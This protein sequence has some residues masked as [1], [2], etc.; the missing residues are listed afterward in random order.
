MHVCARVLQSCLIPSESGHWFLL[1]CLGD[2][3]ITALAGPVLGPQHSTAGT[4]GDR[5][6]LKL[7]NPLNP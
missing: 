3:Y 5:L 7:S 2:L 4:A 6:H 1:P